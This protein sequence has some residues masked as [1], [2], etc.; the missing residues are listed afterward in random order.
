MARSGCGLSEQWGS[1]G[2]LVRSAWAAWKCRW[3]PSR[4]LCTLRRCHPCTLIAGSWGALNGESLFTLERW[5][6]YFGS[7]S[8]TQ[9]SGKAGTLF[10]KTHRPKY[11]NLR[12][13][14]LLS[15]MALPQPTIIRYQNPYLLCYTVD[16]FKDFI[17]S[18]NYIGLNLSY[19]SHISLILGVLPLLN[20]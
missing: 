9:E 18:V 8:R 12:W 19:L 5:C 16:E 4:A 1:V 10:L 11:L 17:C 14:T 13:K 3:S 2:F 20:V 15:E 6:I 7:W